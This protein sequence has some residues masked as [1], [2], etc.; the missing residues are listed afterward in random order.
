VQYLNG[1][2]PALQPETSRHVSAGLVIEPMTDV[3]I[4]I[5]WWRL[6][7][8]HTIAVLSDQTVL[9][10]NDRY[11][12]KNIVRGPVDPAFPNLPGPIT[13]LI[14]INENLGR[15]SAS[16][17]DVDVHYRAPRT[18]FGVFTFGLSG[19]YLASSKTAFDGVDETSNIANRPRWQH[20]LTAY[21]ERAPWS[22]TLSQTWRA[23]YED[24]RPDLDGNARH[25]SPYRLWN[26]QV[27]YAGFANWTLAVGAKNLFNTDPPFSNQPFF[28]QT[29]Y[30]PSYAD[31]RGRVLYARASFRWL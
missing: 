8:N 20:T 16:G 21:W 19:T 22:A 3:S 25:V 30:D 9:N 15:Q 12:G 6:V 7:L 28:G 31:P 1:G 11:E 18:G 24:V 27:D 4:G 17:V 14:E 23:G 10:G 13:K 2:N 5:N 29:G 26:C